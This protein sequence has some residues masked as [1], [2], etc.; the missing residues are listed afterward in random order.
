MIRIKKFNESSNYIKDVKIDID[1]LSE[2]NKKE[3]LDFLDSGRIP[4]TFKINT[5]YWLHDETDDINNELFRRF[6][7]NK[8][9][10]FDYSKNHDLT[11]FINNLV[12]STMLDNIKVAIVES[13]EQIPASIKKFLTDNKIK[14]YLLNIKK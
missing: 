4:S 3:F 12:L 14:L 2:K 13:Q 1:N 8:T 7:D 6:R 10:R 11:Y 5:L 9:L